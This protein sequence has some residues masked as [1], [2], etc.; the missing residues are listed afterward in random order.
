MQHASWRWVFFITGPIGVAVAVLTIWRVQE[1]GA[2]N[3]R[4][5]LDWGGAVLTTTGLGGIVYGFIEAAPTAGVVGALSLIA[6]LFLESRSPAPMLPLALF[7][8]P[9]FTGANLLTLL[10]Y[11]ALNGVLFFFPLNLIQVQGYR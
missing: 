5:G 1:C 9:S 10:L 3:Q 11:F 8:S 6:F 7:R 2:R 4:T